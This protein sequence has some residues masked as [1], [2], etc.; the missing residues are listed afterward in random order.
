MVITKNGLW[1]IIEACIYNYN[2]HLLKQN[3]MNNN[4][5][6]RDLYLDILF[7]GRN[8]TYGAYELR[9]NYDQRVKR[10]LQIML[11]L[12]IV[13]IVSFHAFSKPPKADVK[14]IEK[15][16]VTDCKF[17]E[18]K[19][20]DEEE[21]PEKP[22]DVEKVATTQQVDS[23]N[24]IP[25]VEE[26]DE[27]EIKPE[28]KAY[29]PARVS[30]PNAIATLGPSI[31]GNGGTA[32]PSDSSIINLA[33][34][35]GGS[36]T[37]VPKPEVIPELVPEIVTAETADIEPE[38]PGGLDQLVRFVNSNLVYPANA[39]EKEYSCKVNLDFVV[40][41]FGL[42]SN[43]TIDDKVLYGCDKEARRVVAMM[44]KWRP[45]KLK[46]KPVKC[47][48]TLPITFTLDTDIE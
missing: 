15:W 12:V 29:E 6:K 13:S 46:G 14:P 22:K 31:A 43:I 37:K 42:I 3:I 44:P 17:T 28:P 39:V 10:S 40:D 2:T 32:I 19:T 1:N 41:E 36:G 5:N 21:E 34:S 16:I 33:G 48:F 35:P 9:L 11:G 18:P 20:K 25:K 47:Y 27:V 30:D 26:D 45:A 8:K 24:L 23:K 4:Q 38:F 7:S